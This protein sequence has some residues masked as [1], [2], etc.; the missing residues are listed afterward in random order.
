MRHPNR[1][2]RVGFM[3]TRFAILRSHAF[4]GL[5]HLAPV[6]GDTVDNPVTVIL[7][8]DQTTLFENREMIGKFGSG[9]THEPVDDADT[10]RLIFN[11]VK[12]GESQRIGKCMIRFASL[13]EFFLLRDAFDKGIKS[14]KLFEFFP[15]F[16]WKL[17]LLVLCA[18]AFRTAT[19]FLH[20]RHFKN[21]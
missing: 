12:D 1:K 15:D 13:F 17:H 9:K 18:L 6:I 7:T 3:I 16:F 10:E 21:M 14:T 2:E 5:Q 19:G 11:Q 4:S 20:S 8:F